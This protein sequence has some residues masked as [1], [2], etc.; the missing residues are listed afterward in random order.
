[1]KPKNILKS[2]RVQNFK[3]IQDS[4]AVS[5]TPL[6]VFIGNN[7][8]GK[9]SFIEAME[10]YQS[11]VMDGLD[12]AMQKW[13]G[14]EHVWNKRNMKQPKTKGK[15]SVSQASI[16]FAMNG[17]AE[18]GSYQTDLAI[19]AKANFSKIWIQ[20][21]NLDWPKGFMG[22]LQDGKAIVK[23]NKGK[24]VGLS[25][26]IDSDRSALPRAFRNVIGGWQFLSLAPDPMGKPSAKKMASNGRPHLSR[27]GSNLAQYLLNIR[28]Q[29]SG[30]FDDIVETMRL[31]LDY[32]K[33]FEPI[34]SQDIQRMI[35]IQM[36]ESNFEIPGWLLSTG[37]IRI[38]ALLAVLR[39][40]IPPPLIVVEEIENGLDP[41]TIHM[42]LDEIREVVHSGQSQVILTTHSPYLLDLLPLQ[43]LI[44][45]ERENGGD[46]IFWRPSDSKE[47]VEWARQFAPGQLY[48]A[49]RFKR[50][51]KP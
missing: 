49:D 20:E 23:D 34:E 17:R 46:P 36:R 35:R 6:T 7:G 48:T 40:P 3:A 29:D 1:M 26:I 43:T 37:T 16:R 41:R 8:S 13:F 19:S 33:S 25:E 5:L 2:F 10:T 27:D 45:V 44:L 47:I 11:I 18:W 14:F 38:L 31:V 32:A 21:E 51:V 39:N 28:E 42:I 30:A 24:I 22:R 12:S 15:N 9:S 50:E 4:R